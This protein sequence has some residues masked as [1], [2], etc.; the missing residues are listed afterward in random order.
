MKEIYA[1]SANKDNKW[2]N[3]IEHL[4]DTAQLAEGFAERINGKELGYWAG[5][6]HDAGKFHSDYQDYL[7]HPEGK[8]KVDHSS[9]G[10]VLS[11]PKL[12]PI[13][14]Y[15]L[16]G[17][18][19]GLADSCDLKERL[20]RKKDE[21]KVKQAIE[22]A[23]KHLPEIPDIFLHS[24][25]NQPHQCELFIRMLFSCLVDADFLNTEAHF[26]PEKTNMRGRCFSLSTL[27]KKFE[28]NQT[29]LTGR[30]YDPLN[31][32][33]HEIYTTCLKSA[34]LS[35]GI[36]QLTV[37]TG[38]GKTRSGIAFALRHCLKYNIDRIIVAIPYTSIIEQTVSIYREIFGDDMVL[39]H[40]SAV[41]PKE[42]DES[43]TE[44]E[45]K[46]QLATE[47]WNAPIVVTTTVQLFESLFANKSSRCRK[48]H[49]IARSVVILDE[50]QTLPT[51]LLTPIIN[52]LQ[53]LS[54]NYGVTIVLCT[55]TQPA[56]TDPNSPYL[57]GFSDVREIVPNPERY[58]ER[59]RRVKYEPIRTLSWKQVA[60]EM[61]ATNQCL[62]VVNTKTDAIALLDILDDPNALHLSTLLCGAHRRD[63][64]EEVRR[65]LDNGEPC[66]LVSTQVVE[67]GVDLDFPV[68]LRAM[69]PL[70]RIVQAAGRCNREGQMKEGR[71]VIFIPEEGRTPAGDYKTATDEARAL[72]TQDGVDMHDPSL[73]EQY[74][75]RLYQSIETDKKNIQEKRRGLNY[76]DVAENFQII[77]NPTIP[78]VVR[79]HQDKVAKLLEELKY[80]GI[81]RSLIRRLQPYLVSVYAHQLPRLQREQLIQ[82][83]SPGLWE[84]QGGYDSVRGLTEEARNPEDLVF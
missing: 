38:G 51:G 80:T 22:L 56:I 9:A 36:F 73:Y 7:A 10:A 26:N 12:G 6:W 42:Q 11:A 78:V 50:V 1:H 20:T 69:G 3:L 82:E 61:Q 49:N 35:P 72:L 2:H 59:L 60:D 54:D 40:H 13:L 76:R 16:A 17:H 25:L 57:K 84:W 37:P 66:Y 79:Y 77:D 5:L 64:L 48:L 71:V 4:K 21:S 33:R 65:R 43:P 29:K 15:P 53:D 24:R 68:V 28:V 34:E 62:T 31:T 30:Y 44:M 46:A 32:I 39:E 55:A 14:A 70:D 23:L 74:F 18:H 63:V 58:F 45:L 81:T 27:W 52:V 19:T 67:A 41:Q 47:N 8:Q 83:L 75:R